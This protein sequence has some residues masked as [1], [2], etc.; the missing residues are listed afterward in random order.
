MVDLTNLGFDEY[1]AEQV[2]RLD[3]ASSVPA[4][5]ASAHRDRYEVWGAVFEGSALL[6]PKLR[7]ATDEKDHVAVGDWVMLAL[8]SAERS[9]AVIDTVLARRTAFVRGASGKQSRAQ[10]V[11]ANVDVTFVVCG[12]DDDYNLRR[13]ERY[14]ARVY[15]SGAS[16]V[17]LLNKAD[18]CADTAE[19]VLEVQGCCI[20]VPVYA[21]S[22]ATRE[23]LSFITS[24]IEPGA[25]GA[26]VGS[27]GVGK[28]SL[29]NSI[30]GD[31]TMVTAPVR[32]RDG[33]GVHTTTHRQLIRLPH[34]GLIIDTPG[35]RELQL[36]DENGLDEVFSEIE[37]LA[38][39]C[40][41]RDCRHHSE[42]GCAVKAAVEDGTLPEERLDHY[43]KLAKE[44][45]A[46]ALRMD[47]H[48]RK[49]SEK[50]WGQLHKEAALIR[51]FKTWE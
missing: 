17:V 29:I 13:I 23:G 7:N 36:V 47:A 37:A 26:F 8:P 1:F 20:G 16:P 2:R 35:M 33:R 10:V 32:A 50:V 48:Q 42:P 44:A 45:Q 30:I 39:Q 21:V 51:K 25:T 5:V 40:R 11:A 22:A 9:D 28:S 43:R 49:K 12:L 38:E 15:A 34:G 3:A 41:F 6:S 24:N 18:M 19:R 4:R 14:L 31:D 46:N 27:S